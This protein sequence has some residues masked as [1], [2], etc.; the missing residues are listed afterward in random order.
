MNSVEISSDQFRRLGDRVT[1]LATE[2]LETLDSR[3]IAPP[4]TGAETVRLFQTAI[5]EHGI[6]EKAFDLLSEVIRCSRAQNG[7]FFAYVLGSGEPVGAA[8]DLL[9]SVLN[10]NATAWRSGPAAMMIEQTVVNWLAQAMGCD[11]FRGHLTGGGSSANLMGLA[12]AREAKA[13]ANEKGV[14]ANGV[15]YAS[16]EVH[17]S[18]P[19]SVALLGIGRAN[20]RLV[21]TDDSFRMKTEELDQQIACDKARGK[22][23]IAIVASAGTVNTGAIDPLRSIA[24]IAQRHNAWFHIDGAYG[25]LAAIAERSK[26]DGLE[27][28]DSISLD[29]HKWLYQPLDCG[30][31]LYRSAEAAQHAFSHSG[32]YARVL[33]ADPVE[34]FAFFEESIELSR[35]FRA[36][37][38]WLS[39]RY[40]GLEAF[41]ESIRK[42]LA[43]AQRLAQIVRNHSHLELLAPVE[44]SAVCFRHHALGGTSEEKLNEFNAAVLKRI[45]QRGRV[46]LSNATLRGKF[47][48]RACIV[49]HRTKDAD[50]DT[51]LPEIEAATVALANSTPPSV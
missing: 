38:L 49:N 20:L 33:N 15:V 27:L 36:L 13:P 39:L 1:K 22:I 35:R 28:A 32:D 5:P 41:R 17:M 14:S 42:D 37:K 45:V 10:Q 29:P 18:I 11:G 31:L 50:I 21:P 2:Y 46:Y 43:H 48:L 6:G 47:C 12:M 30:C 7:R 40:H 23:P 16:E 34:G 8:G 51:I 4:T 19:K 9:V 3:P 24:Q 26:F 44:L 25:A